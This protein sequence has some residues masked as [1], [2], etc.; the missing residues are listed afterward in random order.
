MCRKHHVPTI[1]ESLFRTTGSLPSPRVGDVLSGDIQLERIIGRGGMGCIYEATQLRLHRKVALKT[2]HAKMLENRNMLARFY[3][4]ARACTRLNGPHVVRVYDFGVD[5]RTGVPFISME[6]LRGRDLGKILGQEGPLPPRRVARILSQV[7]K[8]LM[9]ADE[10]QIVHRDLKCENIMI[11]DTVDGADFV[12]VMDFGIAKM[13]EGI[14]GDTFA[15]TLDNGLI[16]GSPSTMSPEQ[17]RG[18]AVDFR[19]DLYSLGC[20]MVQLIT[21]KPPY[22]GGDAISIISRHFS[23]EEAPKLPEASGAPPQMI[24]LCAQLLKK[25]RTERPVSIRAVHDA[26]VALVEA[27]PVAEPDDDPAATVL[28]DRDASRRLASTASPTVDVTPLPV[29]RQ[30]PLPTLRVQRPRVAAQRPGGPAP[31]GSATGVVD[32][33]RQPRRGVAHKPSTG[34][35]ETLL[36]IAPV[37]VG[38][39]TVPAPTVPGPLPR[40]RW[41]RAAWIG[42]AVGVLLVGLV[43][44]AASLGSWTG[45][46]AEAPSVVASAPEPAEPEV[47]APRAAPKSLQASASAPGS[48]VRRRGARPPGASSATRQPEGSLGRSVGTPRAKSP[49]SA[50][51]VVLGPAPPRPKPVLRVAEAE[52]MEGIRRPLEISAPTTP[53]PKPAVAAAP[54]PTE[55]TVRSDPRASVYRGSQLVGRT[56]YTLALASDSPSVVLRLKASGFSSKRVRIK[57]GGRTVRHVNLEPKLID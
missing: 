19:S 44:V 36:R 6:F 46:K 5:T 38:E 33:H 2:L 16:M 41:G 23:S 34:P 32:R 53:T 28:L 21:G 4:E 29:T 12:K 55:Y 15:I 24:A 49:A 18:E 11:L 43:L 27:G 56:P 39:G 40:R 14:T 20:I 13:R 22:H 10:A 35:E 37:I 52:A 3:Q 50:P 1:L 26:L 25:D 8:A 17:G 30:D 47:A 45:E 42:V 51:K 7:C 57:P 9:E 31:D 54:E 48:E